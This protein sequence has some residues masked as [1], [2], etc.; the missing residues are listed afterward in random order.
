MAEMEAKFEERFAML[1]MTSPQ[2]QPY[3]PLPQQYHTTPQPMQTAYFTPQPPTFIPPPATIHVPSPQQPPLYQQQYLAG[4]N[5][6]K[7]RDRGAREAAPTIIG[8]VA[9]HSAR[10]NS[11]MEAAVEVEEPQR[12]PTSTNNP[13]DAAVESQAPTNGTKAEEQEGAE[14]TSGTTA[15]ADNAVRQGNH[16]L[17]RGKST[18]T[19]YIVTPAGT[20]LTTPD[21]NART[22]KRHIFPTCPATRHTP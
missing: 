3:A 15:E 18:L 1:S 12:T 7:D 22:R 20:T 21:G 14:T 2:P 4:R 6:A 17:T 11:H 5:D 9:N 10:T 16:I 19:S 13:T 8:K